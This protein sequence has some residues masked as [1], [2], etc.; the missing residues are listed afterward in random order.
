MRSGYE[1]NSR[2]IAVATGSHSGELPPE[3]SFVSIEPENLIITALKQSEDGKDL[4]LRFYEF[5]GR[6]ATAQ[7]AFPPG[8]AEV[9]D[10]NLMEQEGA[11][12]AFDGKTAMVDV[13]QNEIKTLK[14]RLQTPARQN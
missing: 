13:G 8:V 4:I 12:V 6:K 7:I 2:L 11:K 1:L 10:A 3:H 9:F 14:L 5:E